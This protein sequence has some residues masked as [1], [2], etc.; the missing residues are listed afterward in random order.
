MLL[1]EIYQKIIRLSSFSFFFCS[2]QERGEREKLRL[3]EREE[4]EREEREEKRTMK[5]KLYFFDAY[6]YLSIYSKR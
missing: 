1:F 3:V 2:I 6:I 4:K 5:R